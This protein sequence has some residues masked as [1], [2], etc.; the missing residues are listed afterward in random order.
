MPV[1]LPV[2]LGSILALA[3]G[4]TLLLGL[5]ACG[6][7]GSSPAAPSAAAVATQPPGATAG[8]S[9]VATG[10]G[11]GVATSTAHALPASPAPTGVPTPPPTI[12]ATPSAPVAAEVQVKIVNFA[13]EPATITIKPGTTVVWTNTSPTQHTTTSRQP[14]NVWDSGIM[15]SGAVFRFT[16]QQAGEFDY[17]CALHPEMLG[18]VIVKP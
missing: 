8:P 12:A 11:A 14:A 6:S 15:D 16:F 13:F 17:W 1:R 3:L 2:S 9:P 4:L 7:G 5:A 10:A 18:K